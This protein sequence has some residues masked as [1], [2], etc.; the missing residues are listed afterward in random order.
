MARRKPYFKDEV[1]YYNKV[2]F[3]YI[4]LFKICVAK[5]RLEYLINPL[6]LQSIYILP[7]YKLNQFPPHVA[8]K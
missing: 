2:S 6:H 8:V 4:D 3:H 7:R 1:Q 5:I